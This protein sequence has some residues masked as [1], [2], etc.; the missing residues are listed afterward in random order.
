MEEVQGL[1]RPVRPQV[2]ALGS[3]IGDVEAKTETLSFTIDIARS[4][5]KLAVAPRR[6]VAYLSSR[7]S[8][9]F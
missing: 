9:R 1:L 5:F 4:S 7:Q 6:P 2:F 8:E 3:A